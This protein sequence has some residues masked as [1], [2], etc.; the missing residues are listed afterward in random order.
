MTEIL[1]RKEVAE[2]FKMSIGTINYL[3]TTG[4]IPFSRLGKRSVRFDRARLEKWF[5]DREMVEY[6][7]KNKNNI[8]L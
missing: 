5:A 6:R 2:M 4:Q 3:V 1:I 8:I 7:R